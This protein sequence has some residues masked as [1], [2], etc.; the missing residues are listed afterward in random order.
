MWARTS[1]YGDDKDKPLV[2]SADES[3]LYFAY[4]VA[5]LRHKLERVE[6]AVYV[7]EPTATA[8]SAG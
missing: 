2:R 1:A 3:Y 8:M 5:Y 6:R 4:D 7:Q